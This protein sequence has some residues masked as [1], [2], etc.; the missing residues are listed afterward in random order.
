MSGLSHG[1]G[2]MSSTPLT[3]W[4][5]GSLV[6]HL[7]LVAF[8]CLQPTTKTAIPAVAQATRLSLGMAAA[9]AGASSQSAPATP[10]VHAQPE[11]VQPITPVE[12]VPQ[13]P[14]TAKS[15]AK[16][17]PKPVPAPAP[18]KAPPLR[19]VTP[20]RVETA[21]K[22]VKKT[23]KQVTATPQPA[24][25]ATKAGQQGRQ[26]SRQSDHKQAETGQA[27][28]QGGQAVSDQFDLTVRRHLLARKQT[29]KTLGGRQRGMVEVEFVIDRQGQLLRQEV[30]QPSRVRE[31]DRAA[32]L[33]V[34]SAAP[35][36][37]AP[38]ELNWQQRRYRIAIHY[39]SR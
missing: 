14:P 2:S 8:Y 39:Q 21:N 37:K 3:H 20:A 29:P 15:T 10:A 7:L 16:Q 13:V 17:R 6:C 26:G 27:A 34:A 4:V 31:F 36:P 28:V 18:R 12:P 1:D 22:V 33:L 38:P 5:I 19:N 35:Y 25:A 23:T 32:R 24:Q 30:G 9:L 11:P